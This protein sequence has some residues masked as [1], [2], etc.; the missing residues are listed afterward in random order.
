MES[1]MT[2]S[3]ESV[4]GA[5]EAH[6]T[7]HGKV[8]YV[9]IPARDPITSGVFYEAVFGWTLIAPDEVRV[10]WT[11]GPRDNER[12]PFSDVSGGLSGAFVATR[13]ASEDGVLLHIYVDDLDG[14]LLEIEGRG[15]E[16]TGPPHEQGGI[17]LAQF[18][19]PG[20]NAIGIWEAVE[21]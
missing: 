10:A 5:I 6:L 12:V 7:T 18:R 17:R 21:S 2:D 9:A 20:G 11:L 14:T 3:S 13:G 1:M 15:F 19:D 8:S 16:I 4:P